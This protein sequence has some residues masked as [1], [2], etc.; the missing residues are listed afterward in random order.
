MKWT[1]ALQLVS[2]AHWKMLWQ[3]SRKLRRL[4]IRKFRSIISSKMCRLDHQT[5]PV[6]HW[7]MFSRGENIATPLIC[8]ASTQTWWAPPFHSDPF[9]WKWWK[10][11]QNDRDISCTHFTVKDNLVCFF[12]HMPPEVR[13]RSGKDCLVWNFSPWLFM[14]ICM[15]AIRCCKLHNQHSSHFNKR[16]LLEECT[17]NICL[18]D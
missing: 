10:L 13:S 18:V 6:G 16:L 9:F 8:H 5:R 15:A 2:F 14:V 11:E 1:W 3:F 4:Q 7:I 17:N 12:A